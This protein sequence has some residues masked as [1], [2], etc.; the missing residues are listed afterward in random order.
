MSAS[1]RQKREIARDTRVVQAC[2]ACS[3]SHLRCEDEKPCSR[4]KKKDI[5]CRVPKAVST[6]GNETDEIDAVHAA[7]DL[8][9]LSNGFDYPPSAPEKDDSSRPSEMSGM[10]NIGSSH[11]FDDPQSLSITSAAIMTHH[12]TDL[13]SCKSSIT[14]PNDGQ[15]PTNIQQTYT[16]DPTNALTFFDQSIPDFNQTPSHNPFL[17]DYFRNLPTFET[18][19]SGQA[20]P[21]GIM[22]LSFDL[23]TGFTEVDLGLL[24]QYNL[25]VPFAAGTPSTASLG[26]EVLLEKDSVP[27]QTEA[28]KKSI[29][30]YLPQSSKDFGG[31]EQTDLA[32]A[33]DRDGNRHSQITQCRLIVEKLDRVSRDRLM[34][35]VLGT[36]SPENVRRIASAFPSI[37]LLDGLIQYFFTS[38][39]MDAQS[40]LHLPTFSPSKISPELLACIVS[41]GAATTPDIPLRKLGFALNE[42]S[43]ISVSETQH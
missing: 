36:C 42:A 11:H 25:Q 33:D 15:P 38:P 12:G 5:V 2:E 32:F 29:W 26:P 23:D 19:Y 13:H 37:E 4:C 35:L 41:A 16:E 27:A 40:W 34:A 30:R 28:F 18:F 1:K 10:G 24:D 22:D 39:A 17:P 31:A 8:L 9:D 7:H 43:R 21:R 20:I 3:Q 14:Q 6:E